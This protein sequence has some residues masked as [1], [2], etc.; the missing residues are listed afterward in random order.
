MPDSL[1]LKV[2]QLK[3]P[4][5]PITSSAS[6][7]ARQ[8]ATLYELYA[9]SSSASNVSLYFASPLES[10]FTPGAD[11]GVGVPLYQ[12]DCGVKICYNFQVHADWIQ[13]Q[14]KP[15]YEAALAAVL[16]NQWNTSKKLQ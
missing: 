2:L 5:A 6:D 4:F 16:V 3:T 13:T 15:A 14:Y 7:A 12:A 11:A 10:A 1:I 8:L 9:V